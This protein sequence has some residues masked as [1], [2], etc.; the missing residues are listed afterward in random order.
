MFSSLIIPPESKENPKL[1]LQHA[2]SNSLMALGFDLKRAL[3]LGDKNT[4]RDDLRKFS[5][6][7]FNQYM[8]TIP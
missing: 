1:Y 6:F 3:L 8:Y 7:R 2:L 4:P 5:S